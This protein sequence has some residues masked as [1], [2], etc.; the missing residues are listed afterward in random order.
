VHHVPSLV[1]AHSSFQLSSSQVK[2]IKDDVDKLV[3][4]F[5][6]DPDD[7]VE[8]SFVAM[9][10]SVGVSSIFRADIAGAQEGMLLRVFKR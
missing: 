6:D 10:L 5:S 4:A 2:Q 7:V 9:A 3:V 8:V 1:Y